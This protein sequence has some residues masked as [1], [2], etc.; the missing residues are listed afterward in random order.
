M[1]MMLHNFSQLMF[2]YYVIFKDLHDELSQL[3][4]AVLVTGWNGSRERRLVEY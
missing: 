1:N 4:P 2:V 3:P